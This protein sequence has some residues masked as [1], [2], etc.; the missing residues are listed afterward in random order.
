MSVR[1]KLGIRQGSRVT[2]AVRNG[3]AEMRVLHQAPE[4]I[5]SGYGMVKVRG[6]HLRADVDPAMLLARKR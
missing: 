5:A 4:R 3:R 1:R 6:R 2:F